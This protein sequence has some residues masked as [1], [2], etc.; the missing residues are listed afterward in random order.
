MDDGHPA[1]VLDELNERGLRFSRPIGAVVVG[2]NELVFGEIGLE[3]GIGPLWGGSELR[4]EKLQAAL[5]E[6]G[7]EAWNR[8]A[9]H[10]LAA[11]FTIDLICG[12]AGIAVQG[13]ETIDNTLGSQVRSD[14]AGYVVDLRFP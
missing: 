13:L 3:A 14:H 4:R 1:A 11:M 8:C 12:P 2:D 10:A 6:L 9:P 5:A 7:L